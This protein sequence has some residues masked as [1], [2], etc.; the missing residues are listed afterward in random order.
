MARC[1]GNLGRLFIL[2]DFRESALIFY[3]SAAR[4]AENSPQDC[5]LNARSNPL[6]DKK[7]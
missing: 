6:Q 1:K 5:F 4:R 2:F 3:R 7:N